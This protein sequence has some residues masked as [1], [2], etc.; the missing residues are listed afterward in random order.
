M[1]SQ[2][3]VDELPYL[4]IDFYSFWPGYSAEAYVYV[5]Q[6]DRNPIELKSIVVTSEETAEAYHS[7]LDVK[8]S[9][10]MLGNKLYLYRYRVLDS[11]STEK[12]SEA[13]SL[14]VRL[15]WMSPGQ[16]K[17]ATS[18]S[19]KRQERVDVVWPT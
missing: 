7:A 19:L 12:F 9:L 5:V 13:N 8:A 10:R 3:N 15:V 6:Q 18:F 11:R 16:R 4:V 14:E 2:I 17:R 1:A